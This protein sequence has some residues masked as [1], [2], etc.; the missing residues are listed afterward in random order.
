MTT[1]AHVPVRSWLFLELKRRSHTRLSAKAACGN[2][3]EANPLCPTVRKRCSNWRP[4]RA[5]VTIAYAS[6]F[7]FRQRRNMTF[8]SNN[9]I[10]HIKKDT[11]TCQF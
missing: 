4:A 5:S 9:D 7:P 6:L 10:D 11:V 1:T 3:G 2:E 8:C